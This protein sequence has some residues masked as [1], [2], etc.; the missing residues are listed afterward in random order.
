LSANDIAKAL[1]E[2]WQIPK[3]ATSSYRVAI[4]KNCRFTVVVGRQLPEYRHMPEITRGKPGQQ[5]PQAQLVQMAM[6]HWVHAF[7]ILQR[8]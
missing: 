7:F 5:P 2:S 4:L 6:A 3:P 1:A 8:K